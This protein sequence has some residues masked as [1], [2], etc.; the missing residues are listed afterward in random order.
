MLIALL[1]ELAAVLPTD[2]KDTSFLRPVGVPNFSVI[3]LA[4]F[5]VNLA[6]DLDRRLKGE[7]EGSVFLTF[8]FF[9]GE[10]AHFP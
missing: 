9:E 5:I 2:P 6:Y 7:D 3:I 4:G 10:S 8:F 1:F